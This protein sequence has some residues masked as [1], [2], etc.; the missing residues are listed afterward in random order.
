[1]TA[2]RQAA[3]AAG[4]VAAP[5]LAPPAWMP[6]DAGVPAG[7]A[8]RALALLKQG[9]DAGCGDLAGLRADPDLEP[10]AGRPD[11]RQLLAGAGALRRYGSVWRADLGR[12]GAGLSGLSAEAHLARC[13]ELAGQ[14]W[15][16]AALSVAEVA[17]ER[18]P[19]AASAWHRRVL[20]A[21]QHDRHAQRQASAAVTLLHLGQPGRAWPLLRHSPD[22]TAR[23]YLVQR[24]SLLGVDG[25]LLARRLVQ[26]KDV[27]ARRA[28]V[29]ALGEYPAKDLPARVRGPLVKELLGWYRDHPDPG[30]HGAIDWLLR[31]GKE[32]PQPRPLDWGQRQAL[33]QVDCALCRRDPDGRRG[34]YVN[35]Q[36]QTLVLIPGPVEFRMG[37]PPWEAARQ[38]ANERPH[39]RRIG[40][41]YAI[42]SKPVTV[43]QWERF[44]KDRPK[45]R[46]SY[47]KSYSPKPGGPII[48][49]T[50]YEAAAYCNWLSEKEGIPRDQ[51]CYP[52]EI[53]EGM[54][55][56]PDY[57]SR[58][59]YRLPT[60]A[61]WEHACR[62]G[63]AASRCY[64]AATDLLP[65]YAWYSPNS[66]ART[67][68]VGKTRPNDLGLFD[69]HGNVWTWCQE[70][71]RTYPRGTGGW[72]VEDKEDIRDIK[73]T[74][75]RVLRGASFNIHAGFVRSARRLSSRP[76]FRSETVGLRP[77]RT[78]H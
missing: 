32:G 11:Y 43:A 52:E 78:Y 16:P 64:G 75:G 77:A 7:H 69:I 62:A 60:E 76:S 17:G 40:R 55:P 37:S 30:L 19:V 51:W 42:A 65:R 34:W 21:R 47:P 63:S 18:G 50:W 45:I 73:D 49:V 59:G 44:L 13:R 68:P 61:E 26:E 25:R 4:L 3:W 1:V 58:T 22:P 33:E 15:R 70:S 48:S 39:R 31:H 6:P 57:L 72:P 27:S 10:L 74:L 5:G 71:A 36:G 66:R 8:G 9:L 54:K 23:S 24:A 12:E 38:A 28:L 35:G 46:H 53:E 67:W 41:S 56:Y 20:P 2:A 29:L 14:G